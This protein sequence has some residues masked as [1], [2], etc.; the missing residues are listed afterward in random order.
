MRKKWVSG[1]GTLTGPL[2]TV[3]WDTV[4]CKHCQH[5]MHVPHKVSERDNVVG[6][7]SACDSPICMECLKLGTCDVIEKKLVR[8]EAKDAA[9]R[10]YGIK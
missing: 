1:E 10:S 9:I 7:C 6:W 3:T 4:T 2:Q 8:W 5:I